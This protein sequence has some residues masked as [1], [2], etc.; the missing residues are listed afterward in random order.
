MM[1]VGL[2]I[3]DSAVVAHSQD[4]Q[5]VGPSLARAGSLDWDDVTERRR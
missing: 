1:A 3:C 4:P 2:T 5:P